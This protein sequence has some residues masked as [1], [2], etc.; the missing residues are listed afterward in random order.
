MDAAQLLSDVFPISSRLSALE[1]V[2]VQERG[3]GLTMTV[4]LCVY[5]ERGDERTIRDV[6]EQEVYTVSAAH[7]EDPRLA[8]CVAGWAEAVRHVLA[9]DDEHERRMI[10]EIMPHE[11]VIIGPMLALKRP[12]TAEDFTDAALSG[13]SRLGK[14]L[15]S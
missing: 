8:A 10:D 2:E 1:L 3:G 12:R 5:E 9:E 4:R 15:R 11:L 14:F 6:R 7:R 13:R